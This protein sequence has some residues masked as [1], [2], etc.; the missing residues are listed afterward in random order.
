MDFDNLFLK[1]NKD[2]ELGL[3][4]LLIEADKGIHSIYRDRYILTVLAASKLIPAKIKKLEEDY[5]LDLSSSTLNLRA[6]NGDRFHAPCISILFSE[7]STIILPR[8][9][10]IDF[11][12]FCDYTLI[13]ARNYKEEYLSEELIE[14]QSIKITSDYKQLEEKL[15]KLL[16]SKELQSLVNFKQ[17][18]SEIKRKELTT[19]EINKI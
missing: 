7:S 10:K 4:D 11:I 14:K 2:P 12:H 15:V 5:V 8:E 1:I 19:K 17:L 6:V 16:L 3:E 18:E 13:Q 9:L